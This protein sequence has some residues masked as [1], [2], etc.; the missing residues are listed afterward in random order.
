MEVNKDDYYSLSDVILKTKY[1]VSYVLNKWWLLL[2]AILIGV[3][4]GVGYFYAQKPRY[5]AVSTFILEEKQTSTGGLGSIASQFG[6]DIGSLGGGSLF[7]GDNIVEILKSK[8]IVQQILLSRVNSDSPNSPTLADLYLEF[9]KLKENW[10]NKPLLSQVNFMHSY[11]ESTIQDSVLK[12]IY[13]RIVKKHLSVDRIAKRGTII[14]VTV[15]ARNGLFAK[16]MTE[17]LV[18]EAGKMY[19]NIKTGTALANINR[20]Q[21]RS[22]SLL[23]L[24][25]NKS[26][27]AASMQPLDANPGI[28]TMSVP[29]EIAGRDKTVLATLYTEVTKN[30]ET[31][32]LILSQQTPIIQILDKPGLSLYDHK[33]SIN[34]YIMVCSVAAFIICLA[35][36]GAAYFFRNIS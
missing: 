5:E 11:P 34:F 36:L 3:G 18:D 12:I 6:I 19:L 2:L 32:K 9:S 20:L 33:R 1:F 28:K 23:A 31:S 27:T 13:D 17:R 8:R 21:R 7:T 35:F 10:K 24:L 22:D 16:L 30:L 14:Q 29:S 25:N 26:F 15:A 4:V